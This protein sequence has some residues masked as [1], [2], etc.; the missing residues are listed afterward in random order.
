MD[1]K[2]RMGATGGRSCKALARRFEKAAGRL[3]DRLT[4]GVRSEG[5]PALQAVRAAWLGVEVTSTRGGG[6]SSGLRGRVAAATRSAPI[7]KGVRF[8]VEPAAVDPAYGRSLTYGLDG[9]GRWRHP[10]FGNTSAWTTQSG[11]EVFLMT[12]RGWAPKFEARLERVVDEVARE[13]EG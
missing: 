11:Q 13:I 2:I 1:I 9:L 3:Q 4:A 8:E 7:P 6:S 10:V 12:I 5:D